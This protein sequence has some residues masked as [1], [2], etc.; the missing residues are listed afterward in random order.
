MRNEGIRLGGREVRTRNEKGM[1]D[2]GCVEKGNDGRE[3]GRGERE[4]EKGGGGDRQTDRQT[5]R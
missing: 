1:R 2:P 5:Q 3:G 4:G